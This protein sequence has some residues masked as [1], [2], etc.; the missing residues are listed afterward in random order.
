MREKTDAI[1]M[2]PAITK[3]VLL[4]S[5]F[6][7]PFPRGPR[8]LITSPALKSFIIMVPLPLTSYKNWIPSDV[9]LKK[10]NGLLRRGS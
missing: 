4:L 1:P 10:L 3:R 8:I 6:G 2:P 7:Y 5:G 9:F